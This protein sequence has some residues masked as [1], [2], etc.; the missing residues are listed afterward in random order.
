M[1]LDSVELVMAFEEV[2]GISIPDA[3]AQKMLTPQAVIDFIASR[4]GVDGSIQSKEKLTRTEIA[5]TVRQLVIEQLGIK[6][7]DYA[8]NKEFVRDLGMD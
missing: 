6:E 4:R 1:G 7:S 8:E 2:F 3:D 5:G